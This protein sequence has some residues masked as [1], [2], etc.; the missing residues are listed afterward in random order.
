[1]TKSTG[2]VAGRKPKRPKPEKPRSDFSLDPRDSGKFAKQS[3]AASTA[4]AGGM[5]RP[6]WKWSISKVAEDLDAGGT[7]NVLSVPRNV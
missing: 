5:I 2:R 1:M 4:S 3:V 7:P 6:A